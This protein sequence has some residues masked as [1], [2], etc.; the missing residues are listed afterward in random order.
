MLF[1]SEKDAIS[2]I[3]KLKAGQNFSTLAG[4]YSL[5]TSGKQGGNL[6]WFTP[7][8][9]DATFTNA[10]I[11]MR[12]GSFT[13]TPVHTQIGWHVILLEDIQ[14][15]KM[16]PFNSMRAS[17]EKGLREQALKQYLTRLKQRAKIQITR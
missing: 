1:R 5:G 4:K 6:G 3:Q 8:S 15:A 9:M 17:I 10:V 13:T 16:A 7:E 2:V 12:K 11:Q 14:K